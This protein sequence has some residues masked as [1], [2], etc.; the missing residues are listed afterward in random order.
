MKFR[1]PYA[2]FQELHNE[3]KKKVLWSLTGLLLVLSTCGIWRAISILNR[4]D[5]EITILESELV[6]IVQLL[7]PYQ[8][9]KAEQ[10]AENQKLR[11]NQP[12]LS[13]QIQ[14]A[15]G[16]L[17]IKVQGL[18]GGKEKI[19][20]SDLVQFNMMLTVTELS[21]DRLSMFLDILESSSPND[22]VR[23]MRLQ[24][25]NR[26]DGSD[27]LDARMMVSTWQLTEP[28]NLPLAF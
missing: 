9:L 11:L 7:P 17:R 22:L 3:H 23:V 13:Q 28:Q 1:N 8:Q 26:F 27:L 24:I 2:S 19:E 5:T 12:I 25:R 10:E 18:N 21:M 6:Q 20:N 4:F 15:A 14:N 16:R